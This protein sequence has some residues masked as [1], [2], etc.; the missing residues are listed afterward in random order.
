MTGEP[1]YQAAVRAWAARLRAAEPVTWS[2]FCASGDGASVGARVDPSTTLVPGSGQLEIVRRLAVLHRSEGLPDFAGLADLVLASSGPGRGLVDPPLPWPGSAPGHGPAPVEP[3]LLPGTELVRAAS[4]ALVPLLLR[5]PVAPVHPTA[6]SR[7]RRYLPG[8]H[9]FAVAGTPL[10][11]AAVRTALL[12]AGWVEGGSRA[13]HLVLGRDLESMMAEHWAARTLAGAE[14]RWRPLWRRAVTTE[15][16]PPRLRL[17]EIAARRSNEHGPGAV[18]LV[19]G[20]DAAEIAAGVRAA[21]GAGISLGPIDADVVA[22]DLLRRL[23]PFLVLAGGSAGRRTAIAGPWPAALRDA[24]RSTSRTALGAPRGLLPWA[25]GTA[26]RMAGRITG[27]VPDAAA[28]GDYA[29]HGDPAVL[30]PDRGRDVARTV[31]PDDVADLAV[32][33]IAAL[34]RYEAQEGDR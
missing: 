34:W 4:G 5:S 32:R 27:R 10:T 23:N 24:R 14:R 22:A 12:D 6:S 21:T 18:H 3:D 13:T 29:V 19:L 25:I 33:M 16:L 30:V 15:S 31:D 20:R 17:D 9:R 28:G 26:D 7:L 2:A 1:E 11:A 8:R